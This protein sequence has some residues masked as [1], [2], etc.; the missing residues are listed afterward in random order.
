M[1]GVGWEVVSLPARIMRGRRRAKRAPRADSR[2]VKMNIV[3]G[4][5][6]GIVEW[7]RE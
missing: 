7:W 4:I 6:G 3:G 5:V 1:S 2:V